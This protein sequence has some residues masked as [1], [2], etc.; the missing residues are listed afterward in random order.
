MASECGAR[1]DFAGARGLAFV[2]AFAGMINL[3]LHQTAYGGSAYSA[4][5]TDMLLKLNRY[6]ISQISYKLIFGVNEHRG[7][8]GANG[9]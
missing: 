4:V 8:N 7:E 1:G 5:F 9:S 3:P 2:E 6:V